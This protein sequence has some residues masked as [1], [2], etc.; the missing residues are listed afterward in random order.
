VNRCRVLILVA[1]C[2]ALPAAPAFA[3][4]RYASA[5]GGT[6]LLSFWGVVDPGPVDGIGVGGRLMLPVL[7]DGL[8]RHPRVRDELTLELGA[9]V[10]HYSD[11]V[12]DP[13][14]DY[15]WNGVLP[16][17][18]AT[19]NFWF[20]PRFAAYPKLDLGYWVGWYRGWDPVYGYARHDFGG[21]FLQAALGIVY[22]FQAVALRVEA[23]SGLLR[24]GAGFSY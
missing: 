22:R 8:L 10:V 13:Y 18:G 5:R 7:P 1:L 23:G 15:Q 4:P 6:E 20:T 3:A 9:D 11:R 21:V 17:I 19:W 14:V 16:V 2:S 24:I 12:G